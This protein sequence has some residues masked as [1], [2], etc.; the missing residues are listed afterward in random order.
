MQRA[1]YIM[2]MDQPTVEIKTFKIPPKEA[3]FRLTIAPWIIREMLSAGA[4]SVTFKKCGLHL[5][6]DP[7]FDPPKD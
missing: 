7:V 4:S 5:S 1:C 3:Q 6:I 2:G